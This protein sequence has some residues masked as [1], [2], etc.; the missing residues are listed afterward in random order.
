MMIGR[1]GG[2]VPQALSSRYA[3]LMAV[4]IVG[5]YVRTLA[6]KY[7]YSSGAQPVRSGGLDGAHRRGSSGFRIL[8]ALIRE[9]EL[10]ATA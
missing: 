2:G 8:M 10:R 5:I 7:R 6:L 3:T 1:S 4:G 9:E